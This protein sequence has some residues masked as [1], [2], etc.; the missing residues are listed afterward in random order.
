MT[1]EQLEQAAQVDISYWYALWKQRLGCCP[2][3]ATLFDEMHPAS[4][5]YPHFTGNCKPSEGTAK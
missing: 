4:N 2:N 3:C 5:I 1:D